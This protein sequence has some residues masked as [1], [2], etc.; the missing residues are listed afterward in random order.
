M[1]NNFSSVNELNVPTLPETNWGLK[2]NEK[3]SIEIRP[4][5]IDVSKSVNN[6]IKYNLFLNSN[7]FI[8]FN[9]SNY[10][11]SF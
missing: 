9:L 3:E 10:S 6:Q 1:S 8:H 5:K 4:F 11:L 2:K 7:F